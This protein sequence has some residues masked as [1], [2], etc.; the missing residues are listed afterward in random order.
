MATGLLLLAQPAQVRQALQLSH[1]PPKRRDGG[2]H[3]NRDSRKT[4]RAKKHDNMVR[5][6]LV[7][8]VLFKRA[9]GMQAKENKTGK[10]WEDPG[11]GVG[12]KA[13]R[14]AGGGHQM[15]YAGN[16]ACTNTDTTTQEK[17]RVTRSERQEK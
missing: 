16:Q 5:W 6:I 12:Q 14:I 2:K 7:H 17:Q 10:I 3:G 13:E 9:I 11:R 8:V 15:H 4:S 1:R